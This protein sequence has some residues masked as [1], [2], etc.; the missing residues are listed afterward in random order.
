MSFEHRILK[1]Y[2]SI[3]D[4]ASPERNKIEMEAIIYR[5]TGYYIKLSRDIFRDENAKV[6]NIDSVIENLEMIIFSHPNEYKEFYFNDSY[7]HEFTLAVRHKKVICKISV[8]EIKTPSIR[9][10]INTAMENIKQIR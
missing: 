5:F 7:D 2:Y 3:I 8:K 9:S 6:Y 1:N 10:L 4:S